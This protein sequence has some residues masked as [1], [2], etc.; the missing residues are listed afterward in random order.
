[1]SSLE[2]LTHLVAGIA[3]AGAGV[4]LLAASGRE[5]RSEQGPHL[6]NRLVPLCLVIAPA[7]LGVSL[8]MRGA[9]AGRWPVG[10]RYEFTL[11]LA[12]LLVAMYALLRP[13]VPHPQLGAAISILGLALL[14]GARLTQPAA[15]AIQPLPPVMQGLWFPLH[16]LL[17]A[18]ACSLLGLAGS[19]AALQLIAPQLQ[20]S[21]TVDWGMNLGYV[22]LG[23]GMIAGAIWGELAWGE[24]W[25][26]SIKEVWALAAW[27]A[28]T[29]YM[30]VR[31]R[32]SW[33]G[34]RALWVATLACV[35]ALATVYLTPWLVR[36]TRLVGPPIY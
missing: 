24:Y 23:L 29:I 17:L 20:L 32:R 35:L 27:W 28:C 7:A 18:L 26:W 25:T 2:N 14:I 1:M 5:L 22:A 12:L 11:F 30:H 21:P 4:A 8:A 6:A 13:R 3:L 36:W 10:G 31:H 16:T 19:A 15:P 33:R 9:E 34:A